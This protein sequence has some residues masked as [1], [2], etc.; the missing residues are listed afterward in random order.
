MEINNENRYAFNRAFFVRNDD[1]VFK[2]AVMFSRY[3][4]IDLAVQETLFFCN[5]SIVIG[6]VNYL[7]FTEMFNETLEYTK[8]WIIDLDSVKDEFDWEFH[9]SK[10][11][12]R[13]STQKP[14]DI[15]KV[16]DLLSENHKKV[17]NSIRN[18]SILWNNAIY[19]SELEEYSKRDNKLWKLWNCLSKYNKGDSDIEVD[20]QYL[21]IFK[22]VS[23]YRNENDFYTERSEILTLEQQKLAQRIENDLNTIYLKNTLDNKLE[24]K[25]SFLGKIKKRLKI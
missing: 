10:L 2:I 17:A 21:K 9:R 7:A 20:T 3:Q 23:Y 5:N 12:T 15:K 11:L 22:N 8:K 16:I 14:I 25:D 18:T 19:F 24:N 6:K 1:L 13:F 4:K